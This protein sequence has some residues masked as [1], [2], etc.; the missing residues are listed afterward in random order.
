[1]PI[2]PTLTHLD[3]ALQTEEIHVWHT[4][5]GIS[6]Q[7]V[8]RLLGVLDSGEQARAARFLA[9]DARRQYVISHV[10]LR[11]ALSQYL[12]LAA[13]NICFGATGNGKPELIGGSGLCFNLSHTEGTAAIVIAR[14]RR[15]GI[16]VE[17]I[18]GN[19]SPLELATRFF[20]AE[21]REWLRSQPAPEQLAAFF[22]CWTA[23][24]SYIKAVGEGLAMSLTGFAIVPKI[25]TARLELN[26]YGQPEE[27]KK[28]TVWQLELKAGTCAAIAAERD[29]VAIRIGEW[30]PSL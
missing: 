4:D 21:E 19:L 7:T 5:L 24:E 25:G 22:S 27:S 30:S 13:Q 6:V 12:Q 29:D 8:D 2:G 16:D 26:I 18:R 3:G 20:S 15:V 23:K 17:K 11:I 9:A 14:N 10:F 1:M 28:W